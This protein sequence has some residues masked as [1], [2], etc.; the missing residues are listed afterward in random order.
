MKLCKKVS[1]EIF[2]IKLTFNSFKIKNYFP[3]KD[4]IANDLKSFL[5]YMQIYLCKPVLVAIIVTAYETA[6]KTKVPD[7]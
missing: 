5:V 7:G 6:Y 2:N 4:P 3:Y 1:T